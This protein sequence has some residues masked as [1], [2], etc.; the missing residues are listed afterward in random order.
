MTPAARVQAAIELLDAII[1]AAK[2]EGAPA[3]RIISQYFRN[4]RYAG[5]KDRRA[6]REMVYK[7]IRIC[8]EVPQ[9]GRAAMLLLAQDEPA[10]KEL[11]DGSTHGPTPIVEGEAVARRGIVPDWLANELTESDVLP[12]VWELSMARAP[13]DIR[14]NSL[15]ADR[16]MIE[17]PVEGEHLAAPNA[18]RLPA[19]T[20]VEQW[21]AYREGRI[22]IQ[23][24]GS[25]LACLAANAQPGETVVDLCAGAGG[26]TLALAAAM[27]NTGELVASD[28]DRSRLKNLDPRAKR[29]G[30]TNLQ[31]CLL[32]PKRE[33][34]TL[35]E[36]VRRADLV[37]V[38][39]PCSGTGTLRRKPEAKWRLTPDR[40]TRYAGIQD[41][42]LDVATELTKPGGRIAF[43]TCSLLD[44]EGPDRID[45]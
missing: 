3:D 29:A 17:L 34:E 32:D 14:V 13:L 25:Q 11:F 43:V 2:S 5:S 33:L 44:K 23:D 22:E 12:S 26:K 42:V 10:N 30:L 16:S 7:A 24:H 39:A 8:G 1:D 21:D 18:L 38:D 6:V 27:Q 41:H 40:L 36:Y 28:T 37:L 15:T 19:G 4:R 20:Q 45:A 31:M 35:K 9:S